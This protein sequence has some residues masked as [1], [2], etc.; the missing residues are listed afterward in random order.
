MERKNPPS[1]NLSLPPNLQFTNDQLDEMEYN[2]TNE[3]FIK[4]IQALRNFNKNN[5]ASSPS[6]ERKKANE[7]N[8]DWINIGNAISHELYDQIS[9]WFMLIIQK[10]ELKDKTIFNKESIQFILNRLKLD[11]PHLNEKEI[12]HIGKIINRGQIYKNGESQ[13]VINGMY[14]FVL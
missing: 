4:I 5:K 8:L 7:I 6:L 12:E 14:F 1:S 10:H 11:R 2:P 9:S 13:Q 3:A